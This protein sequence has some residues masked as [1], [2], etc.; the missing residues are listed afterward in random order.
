MLKHNI[1]EERANEI[2]NQKQ[3]IHSSRFK[4]RAKI[5]SKECTHLAANNNKSDII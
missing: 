5:I 4:S 1:Y 3:T 2:K